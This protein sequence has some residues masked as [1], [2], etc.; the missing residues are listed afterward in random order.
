MWSLAALGRGSCHRKVRRSR[1]HLCTRFDISCAALNHLIEPYACLGNSADSV[2]GMQYSS[3]HAEQGNIC[4][5]GFQVSICALISSHGMQYYWDA[6]IFLFVEVCILI[7]C[8]CCCDI[9]FLLLRT[10]KPKVVEGSNRSAILYFSVIFSLNVAVGNVS[11]RWVSVNFNQVRIDLGVFLGPLDNFTRAQ[12]ARALVPAVVM[13]VSS[14]WFGKSFSWNLK[15][16]VIPVVLGVILTFYGD[17][18][19]T[20]MGAFYTLFCVLMA[21]LKA[22]VSGELLTGDLKLHPMDLLYKMC[23]LA[24]LQIL[25][26]SILTGEVSEISSRWA[27]LARSAAP[28]VVL[29]SGILS[30]ALNVSSF[31]ANKVTSPLTLCIAANVKQV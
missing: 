23:P 11:L 22:I 31:V 17:M 5:R 19:Y 29:F 14:I 9:I 13:V 10:E 3:Y 2:D 12:V 7:L 6:N 30:F 28:Q 15:L 18:S 24:L 4:C 25:F 21:A 16:A 26:L 8:G 27:E 1:L 20:F